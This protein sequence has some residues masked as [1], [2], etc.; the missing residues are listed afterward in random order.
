MLNT[1]TQLYGKK[2]DQNQKKKEGKKLCKEFQKIT[3]MQRKKKKIL[4]SWISG[5]I[6][7]NFQKKENLK[8]LLKFC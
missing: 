1:K 3:K 8:M 6:F 5:S 2:K 4:I 7:S